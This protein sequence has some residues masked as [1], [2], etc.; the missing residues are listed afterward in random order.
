MS[1]SNLVSHGVVTDAC[2]DCRDARNVRQC[3]NEGD[4]PAIGRASGR[5]RL[6]D[7]SQRARRHL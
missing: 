1:D 2:I 4:V 5:A 6:H 7:R 3:R